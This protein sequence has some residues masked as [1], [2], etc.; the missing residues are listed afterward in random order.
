MPIIGTDGA[1]GVPCGV[2]QHRK[3]DDQSDKGR[4]DRKGEKDHHDRTPNQHDRKVGPYHRHGYAHGRE[5]VRPLVQQHGHG[6]DADREGE[7]RE[8]RPDRTPR[9]K[10]RP[11]GRGQEQHRDQL[12]R[13]WKGNHAEEECV[14]Q[15]GG[16]EPKQEKP[17]Q[18]DAHEQ[19]LIT[20]TRFY[21]D[22]PGQVGSLARLQTTAFFIKTVRNQRA[23]DHETRKRGKER[24]FI[25]KLEQH[26]NHEKRAGKNARSVEQAGHRIC[27]QI[28]PACPKPCEDRTPRQVACAQ[29]FARQGRNHLGDDA[30][31]MGIVGRGRI[32][33]VA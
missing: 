2:T 29:V 5:S 31:S 15:H 22:H 32:S 9:Q 13:A 28:R 19:R 12:I 18:H 1:V 33:A 3:D 10:Q 26:Q 30:P 27:P 17:Q 25:A 23:E 20:G 24:V 8:K 7:G 11:A 4:R 6:E 14:D 16:P 21:K